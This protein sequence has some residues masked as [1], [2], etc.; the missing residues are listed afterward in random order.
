[1][2]CTT[3]RKARR[4]DITEDIYYEIIEKNKQTLACCAL[5]QIS[6]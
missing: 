5:V 3:D 4:L 6:D 1:M 2:K